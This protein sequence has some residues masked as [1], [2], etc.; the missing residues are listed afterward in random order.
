MPTLLSHFSTLGLHKNAEAPDSLCQETGSKDMYLPRRH[1]NPKFSEGGSYERCNANAPPVGKSE[2]RCEYAEFLGVL[3]S[4]IHMSF[5]LPESKVLNL[6][7]D[8]RPLLNSRTAS[9]SDLA[10]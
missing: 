3:V 6:W 4:S 5:S 7:N 10:N 8:H 9:E 1:A 2:V